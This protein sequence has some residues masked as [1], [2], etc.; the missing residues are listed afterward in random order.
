MS[1]HYRYRLLSYAPYAWGCFIR[2]SLWP[3]IVKLSY[4]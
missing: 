4:L 1:D 3:K 2:R